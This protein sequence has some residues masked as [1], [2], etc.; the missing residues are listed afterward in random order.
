MFSPNGPLERL[1][2]LVG[3]AL[4]ATFLFLGAG[5]SDDDAGAADGWVPPDGP[6]LDAPPDGDGGAQETVADI[7][8][9]GCPDWRTDDATPYCRGTAPLYLEFVPISSDGAETFQWELGDSA[10]QSATRAQKTFHAPGTYDAT[11]LVAGSF[12]ILQ[13]VKPGLVVVT[14]AELSSYCEK[15][16]NC[17]T[18]HCHCPPSTTQSLEECPPAFSGVCTQTCTGRSCTVGE[19][20]DLRRATE[21]EPAD[22]E[23]W[24]QPLCLPGCEEDEDCVRASFDCVEVR[25]FDPQSQTPEWVRTCAPPLLNEVGEPCMSPY[26]ALEA[27]LCWSGRCTDLGGLGM[28]T[29]PCVPGGCPSYSACVRFTGPDRSLCV[30]ACSIHHP[31]DDDPLLGCETADPTGYYGFTLLDEPQSPDEEYCAPKRCEE[32][33]QCGLTNTCSTE[34]GGFCQ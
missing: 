21:P 6:R 22:P 3:P 29:S 31:C 25:R 32:P 10:P 8:V 26:G 12:G 23:S 7:L 11:L 1:S 5:C 17:L 13:V 9:V 18:D 14:P 16:E 19:C 28:C 33:S 20:A 2:R 34:L 24:R 15:D 27:D 30:A 4:V